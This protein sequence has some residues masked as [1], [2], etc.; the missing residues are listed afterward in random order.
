MFSSDSKTT[1]RWFFVLAILPMAVLT[2]PFFIPVFMGASMACVS[3][4]VRDMCVDR[5]KLGRRLASVLVPT[6][7]VLTFLVLIAFVILSL[8]TAIQ[9]LRSQVDLSDIPE[10]VKRVQNSA[11][12]ERVRSTLR[13]LG[14]SDMGAMTGDFAKQL[15]GRVTDPLKILVVRL[16]EFFVVLFVFVLSFLGIYMNEH[17]V[18]TFILEQKIVPQKYSK[19]LLHSFSEYSY[20]AF[21]A[22]G[23]TAIAQGLVIGLGALFSGA[24]SAFIFGVIGALSSLLPYVGTFPVSIVI[25]VILYAQDASSAQYITL[26]VFAVVAGLIDNI[27]RPVIVKSR[28]DLH[29]WVAFI[30]IFGGLVFWGLAGVFIGPVLAGMSLDL[31]KAIVDEV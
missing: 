15:L 9:S 17:R 20:S 25:G 31:T 21:A 30:S 27:L 26:V 3:M 1:L 14:I 24:P 28:S 16:P 5:L 6:L 19:V 18:K 7:V 29:P 23:V 4:Q 10:T 22:A 8:S 13:T 11:V 12:V 2:A